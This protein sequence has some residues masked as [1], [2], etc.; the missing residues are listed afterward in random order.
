MENISSN[1]TGNFSKI[2][3]LFGQE[4]TTYLALIDFSTFLVGQPVIIRILWITATSEKALDILNINLALLYNL[5][6]WVTIV[7]FFFLLLLPDSHNKVLR[8]LFT[9]AEIGG[10]VNLS[11]ICFERHVAVIYPT[12]YHLLKKHRFREVCVVAA[13]LLFVPLAF[14][15]VFVADYLSPLRRKMY[16]TFSVAGLVFLSITVLHSSISIALVLKKSSPGTD[17]IHPRMRRAFKCIRA[18]LLTVLICY[19]PVTYMR[20]IMN[21]CNLKASVSLLLLSIASIV[22][23]LL[24]LSNQGKLFTCT[25]QE[26][27]SR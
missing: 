2:Q 5:Q 7:H 4:F 10:P 16:E 20:R 1:D 22:Q 19:I 23:P 15:S 14:V 8:F 13:W 6:H 21:D 26:K 3:S 12:S 27:K 24:Y 9:Y 11:C 18:T 25:R 17:R